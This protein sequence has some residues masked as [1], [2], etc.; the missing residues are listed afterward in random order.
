[1]GFDGGLKKPPTDALRPIIPDNACILCLTAA[2]GTELADAYSPDTVIASSPGKEVHDPWAFYLHAALLRQAF[3]HC[4]K[5]PTAASRRSLGRV[6]VPVW[7]I[8]LSDQLLIIA[9]SG[10][11]GYLSVNFSTI[12]PK[13]PN[14]ALRKVARVRLTSGFEITAYI[15]GIGHNSQEHSSVLVRGGRVK[16]LPGVR[17]HIVRGTL[18]AVGVKDRQQGRSSAL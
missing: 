16:D 14:S 4:G 17:Y 12:T 8:I 13:K 1:M 3:A 6:S 9:L 11:K 10:S 18:D 7:L 15:P 2:A 5:F